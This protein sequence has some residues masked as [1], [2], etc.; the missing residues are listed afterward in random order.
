MNGH[1]APY[2]SAERTAY[3]EALMDQF[4]EH[5]RRHLCFTPPSTRGSNLTRCEVWAVNTQRDFLDKRA[6][7]ERAARQRW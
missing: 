6:A 2:Y 1:R 3:Y 7:V 5:G 4:S